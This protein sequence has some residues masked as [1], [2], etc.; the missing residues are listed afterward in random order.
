MGLLTRCSLLRLGELL[1]FARI[2][3][4]ISKH[5]RRIPRLSQIS[6]ELPA[7]PWFRRALLPFHKHIESVNVVAPVIS[8]GLEYRRTF[9]L[10]AV[11]ARV[12]LPEVFLGFPTL[13]EVSQT[14]CF[15][16]AI[17]RMLVR[18]SC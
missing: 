15:F 14:R 4:G 1:L 5:R 10:Q 13:R 7:I 2:L 17:S 3:S 9:A 12:L 8:W 16:S 18:L 11:D 6:Q